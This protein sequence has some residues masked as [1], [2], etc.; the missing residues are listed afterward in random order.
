MQ[1]PVRISGPRF[2]GMAECMAEIEQSAVARFCFVT[3]DNCRF[4]FDTRFDGVRKR[5][6][7]IGKHPLPVLLEPAEKLRVAEKPILGN[8]GVT[9]THFA[10]R[11]RGQHI[12]IGDDEAWL[13]EHANQ[14]FALR[15]VDACLAA[16][17]RI[18]LRQKRSRDLNEADPASQNACCK[19]S[20]IANDAAAEWH[21]DV[22]AF[23]V[24]FEKFL[25]QRPKFA[26][27]F[28]GF[29]RLQNDRT[30]DQSCRFQVGFKCCQMVARDVFICHDTAFDLAQPGRNERTR[31]RQQS[32][33]NEHIIGAVA[34]RDADS[35]M[36]G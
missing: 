17:R 26:E 20:Q 16:D 14:I 1:Q 27:A 3:R 23:E 24:H 15:R 12:S 28:G 19:S 34:Q 25:T 36:S 8:F 22:A 9:G 31:L 13:M 30:R 11:Q 2:K 29:A 4:C 21:N 33:A 7:A 32:W 5:R 10:R 35:A 18:D 6:A